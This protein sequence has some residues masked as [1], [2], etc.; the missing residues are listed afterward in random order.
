MTALVS[1]LRSFA[2]RRAIRSYTRRLPGL[3]VRD[4]GFSRSYTPLQVR[5]TVE[6][7]GLSVAYSCYAIA[8]FSDRDSFDRFHHATGEQCDYAG[9]RAEIADWQFHGNAGFTTTDIFATYSD[10]GFDSGHGGSHD[11]GGGDGHSGD[12]SH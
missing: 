12:G 2:K 5:R 1:Y 6:R 11:A 10:P 4:Y 9:M 8:M 3:L 7:S